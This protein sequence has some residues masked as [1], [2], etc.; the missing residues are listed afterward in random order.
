MKYAARTLASLFLALA[1]GLALAA[2]L[3]GAAAQRGPITAPTDP[4][5]EKWAAHNL[6]VA[7]Q[8]YSKR[9]AYAGAK[10][11]LLEVAATYPEYTKIDEVYFILGE[12]LVKTNEPAKAR[13]FFERLL[14]ERPES[15]FA[16]R[17][18]E[19]LASLPPAPPKSSP[20]ASQPAPHTTK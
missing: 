9:K 12:C 19:R 14:E 16:R 1:F 10:D 6:D 8:Y 17:A 20:E 18:R 11:R 7:R 3:S 15:E 4:E 5:Q 2:G 13:E